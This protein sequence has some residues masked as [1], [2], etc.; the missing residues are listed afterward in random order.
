[1]NGNLT[2]L[3][4]VLINGNTITATSEHEFVDESYDNDQNYFVDDST[5]WS[6]N[7]LYSLIEYELGLHAEV[8]AGNDKFGSNEVTIAVHKVDGEWKR[9]GDI[10]LP[11][12]EKTYLVEVT[13]IA[14]AYTTIEV[15]ATDMGKAKEI[16]LEKAGDVVFS[17]KDAKYEI[18]D[19]GIK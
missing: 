3:A 17:E 8:L 6:D 16:A 13:R 9:I 14:Y 2:I 5:E 4:N 12:V 19:V 18:N 1:M 7:D 10:S 15:T 11:N